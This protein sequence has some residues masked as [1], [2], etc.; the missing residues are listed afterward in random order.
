[1]WTTTPHNFNAFRAFYVDRSGV[2]IDNA[3]N[4]I[5]KMGWWKTATFDTISKWAASSGG[6]FKLIG[7][8]GISKQ[9]IVAVTGDRL[10]EVH[11][12]CEDKDALIDLLLLSKTLINTCDDY[13]ELFCS[14]ATILN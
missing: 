4:G 9:V 8:F 14:A 5:C 11:M 12:Y 6:E 1:M 13:F 2:E 3:I 7:Q 10:V